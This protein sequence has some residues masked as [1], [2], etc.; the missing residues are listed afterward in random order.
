MSATERVLYYEMHL[1][2]NVHI[3]H[4]H[5]YGLVKCIEHVTSTVI[6]TLFVQMSAL[7]T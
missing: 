4:S 2:G 6:E 5:T 1:L 3:G 7:I